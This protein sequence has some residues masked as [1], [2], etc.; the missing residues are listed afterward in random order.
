MI[1]LIFALI[2]VVTLGGCTTTI[3]D[4]VEQLSLESDENGSVCVR[5]EFDTNPNPFATA[6]VGFIYIEDNRVAE[7]GEELSPIPCPF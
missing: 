5:G 3:S 1:R 6:K 4:V 7:D 2:F